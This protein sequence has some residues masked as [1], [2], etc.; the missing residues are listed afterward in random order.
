M[1]SAH[2]RIFF[3]FDLTLYDT[4]AFMA[5]IR[6]AL[7]RLG[8]SD[9]QV[10]R[11]FTE[12]NASGYSFEA[13]LRLLGYPE[14]VVRQTSD[15]LH[16]LLSRGEKYLLPGVRRGLSRLRRRGNECSLLTYGFPVFQEAK[17]QGV[18]VLHKHFARTHYVWRDSTKGDVLSKYY[19]IPLMFCDDSPEHLLDARRKIRGSICLIRFMWPQFN[20]QPHPEDGKTWQVVTSMDELAKAL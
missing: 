9:E 5:D 13:H 15:R 8:S 2:T 20:L 3:D 12:L 16:G 17:W 19:D 11:G 7:R 4:E 14:V 18:S 6:H 10:N 1:K